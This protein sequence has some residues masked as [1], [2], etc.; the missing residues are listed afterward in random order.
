MERNAKRIA[1]LLKVLANENRLVILCAL[2]QS[3][4]NV[5]SL[6]RRV[7]GISQP[8][9]SQHLA[10]MKAHGILGD[11]KAGQTVTYHIADNRVEAVIDLLGESYCPNGALD[12]ERASG[13]NWV[14]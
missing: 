8:A 3:P 6:L 7:P 14:L 13:V 5:S 4:Q 2:M 10:M 12:G 9:L 11:T 1:E